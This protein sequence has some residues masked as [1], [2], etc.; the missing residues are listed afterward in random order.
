M[1]TRDVTFYETL[2]RQLEQ[3]ADAVEPDK[4]NVDLKSESDDDNE[5]KN[6]STSDIYEEGNDN[7]AT[8][9][10]T[11]RKTRYG[12]AVKLP[13]WHSDFVSLAFLTPQALEGTH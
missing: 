3:V 9:L 13:K 4:T 5:N 2:Y 8:V 11:D 7:D 12:R 10:T 6:S 1:V